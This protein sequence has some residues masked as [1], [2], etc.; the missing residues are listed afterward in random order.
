MNIQKY[1]ISVVVSFVVMGAA[2]F[3]GSVIFANQLA[4]FIAISRGMEGNAVMAPYSM[5]GYLIIT[6]VFA[7][8]FIIMRD[9][10]DIKEGTKCGLLF[11]V[12]MSGMSLVYYSMLPIELP[13]LI[14][15][16]MI[17]IIVYTLGGIVISLLYKPKSE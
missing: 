4:S 8:F 2:G 3:G 16:M 14:A 6:C 13:A 11:G 5:V 12:M 1:I 15:D 7:Y 17:N 10:G 9:T